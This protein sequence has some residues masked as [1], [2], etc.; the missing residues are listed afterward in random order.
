M[1]SLFRK[2]RQRL[3]QQN[4]ITRYLAYAVGEIALVMV[5]ILLAL[6]VNT[7]NENRKNQQFIGVILKEIQ[8]D[9]L[10]DL[11][12]FPIISDTNGYLV[13]RLTM[14]SVEKLGIIDRIKRTKDVKYALVEIPN[15]INRFVIMP[16]ED[17]KINIIMLDDR[18]KQDL[19][20][21][22]PKILM[23]TYDYNDEVRDTMRQL[24][25]TLIDVDK[26]QQVIEEKWPEILKEALSYIK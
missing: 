22:T 21:I 10:N 15:N 13:V 2:I 9:L 1:I 17:G 11:V 24:W 8:Q 18:L 20:K 3:L 23:L 12:E 7:W 16:S 19:L 26:E 5:G 4:R 25:A 14:K 6:Q